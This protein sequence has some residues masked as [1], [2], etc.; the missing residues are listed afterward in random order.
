MDRT[1]NIVGLIGALCLSYCGLPLVIDG[2]QGETF[3]GLN[4]AFL[5]VWLTGEIFTLVYTKTLVDRHGRYPVLLLVNYSVNIVLI[6]V[7][8]WFKYVRSEL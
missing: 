7:V 2:F 5:W 3:R 4:W 6:C 1:I 8:M